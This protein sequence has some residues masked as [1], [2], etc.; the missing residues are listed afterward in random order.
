MPQTRTIEPEPPTRE[1]QRVSVSG[2]SSCPYVVAD[3]FATNT[4]R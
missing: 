3:D 2:L 1:M 4:R